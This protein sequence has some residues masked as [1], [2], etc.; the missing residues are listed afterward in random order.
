MAYISPSDITPAQ[1]S[2][3]LP[4]KLGRPALPPR[5]RKKPTPESLGRG[6]RGDRKKLRKAIDGNYCMLYS[7]WHTVYGIEQ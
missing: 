2:K 5:G 6:I 3:L 4:E 7:M 1:L